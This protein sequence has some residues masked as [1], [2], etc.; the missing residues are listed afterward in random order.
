MAFAQVVC[1]FSLVMR[2]L[3]FV[4]NMVRYALFSTKLMPDKSHIYSFLELLAFYSFHKHEQ[5][6]QF[7]PRDGMLRRFNYHRHSLS[8]SHSIN[9]HTLSLI[10]DYKNKPDPLLNIIVRTAFSFIT[11]VVLLQTCVGRLT[12]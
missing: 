7:F 5:S 2:P 6:E 9:L 4:C 12:D 11:I 1:K 3:F 8:S 10:V